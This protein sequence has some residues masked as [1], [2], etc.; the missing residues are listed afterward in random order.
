MKKTIFI[1]TVLLLMSPCVFAQKPLTNDERMDWWREARFGMFIHWGVYSLPAGTWDGRQIGGIGE[2]IMNRAKIP[3]AD[4]QNM[5]KQ[6]NPVK[7]DPDAWVKMAKDAGMKYIVITSKHHDGFALFETKASKWNV[8]DATPYG[9]DLLKPLAEA[10]K[11]YGIKL[12][13]YYSQAQDWNNPGGSASRKITKEGWANPDSVIIDAY[14][15]EHKGHWDPA[16]EKRTF[17]QYID[18]VAVPQVRELLTNYG[19]L[20]VLWWDTP[21]NMTDEAAKKLQ[22]LLALQP[23]IIT[24]DR[25]KRPNFPGD[26]KTPEQRIPNLADL[27]GTD[28]ET[29][30]TMNGTWGYKSYD[31]NYKSPQKLIQNLLDI[32][33]KGGNFLLN[34]GPTSEG[35]F[36]QESIDILAKMGEWMKINGE[37]VYGSKASPWGLFPW[38]RC[39]K[40]ETKN[41][42][43][44]YFSVFEWPADGKLVIPVLK[45][46]VVSAKLLTNGS[47]VKTS[48]SKD[49]VLTVTLPAAAPDPLATVIRVDVKGKVADKISH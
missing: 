34:V 48:V 47:K 42:T 13:F 16:Q 23:Q 10:C 21:T 20:A 41:S 27:D 8:V 37:A 7:Y 44:L 43:T 31:H 38:G 36:P 5:A 40:K 3:V 9:K 35:E 17:D 11:K 28:W 45:N 6:F 4:Y 1:L 30:M 29:C 12:G 39:T 33:S 2:W 22:S 46:S 26:H 49:G 19:D 32:A 25:L 15:K 24:N 18:D 14:T